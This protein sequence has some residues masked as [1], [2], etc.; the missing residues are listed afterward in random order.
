MSHYKYD[1]QLNNFEIGCKPAWEDDKTRALAQE[2]FNIWCKEILPV[3]S[4]HNQVK[5][6]AYLSKRTEGLSPAEVYELGFSETIGNNLPLAK[7]IIRA[8]FGSEANAIAER[9]RALVRHIQSTASDYFSCN[10]ID[11][12][13][14]IPNVVVYRHA[15]DEMGESQLLR[16]SLFD[17]LRSQDS[18]RVKNYSNEIQMMGANIIK[19]YEQF[20]PPHNLIS[21]DSPAERYYERI[22][23]RLIPELIIDAYDRELV[24]DEKSL[25]IPTDDGDL[26]SDK[27]R[28]T[29]CSSADLLK[30]LSTGGDTASGWVSISA[31]PSFNGAYARGYLRFESGDV[32][33]WVRLHD[34]FKDIKLTSQPYEIIFKN[35]NAIAIPGAMALERLQFTKNAH[36]PTSDFGEICRYLDKHFGDKRIAQGYRHTDL[37]S[38]NILVALAS[39]RMKVIDLSSMDPDLLCVS[40]ARLEVSIWNEVTKSFK[41]ELR[42]VERI[43]DNL[44]TDSIPDEKELPWI[45]WALNHL[46]LSLRRGM[47]GVMGGDIPKLEVVLAYVT[48]VLLNQR[49]FLEQSTQVSDAFN[50]VSRYWVRQLQ[51]LI[52]EV[53]I[54]DRDDSVSEISNEGPASLNIEDGIPT[55]YNLW[56]EALYSRTHSSLEPRSDG[57]LQAIL[58]HRRKFMELPLTAFQKKVYDSSPELR[59]FQSDLHVIIA[60]PTSSGKSTIAEMFLAGPP[61]LN[62]KRVCALY[63]APTRALTQAKYREL[64]EMFAA[65]EQMSSGIVLSTGEDEDD[66]WRINHGMFSIACMVY[67]KANILFSHNRSLLELIGCI[68]VDEMHMLTDLDRGPILE[69]VLTKAIWERNRVDSQT[70]RTPTE[71]SLRIIAISTEDRPDQAIEQFLSIQDPVTGKIREPLLFMDSNRPVRV[72]HALIIPDHERKGYTKFPIVEF[73]STENRRLSE[74]AVEELSRKLLSQETTATSRIYSTRLGPLGEV[75]DRLESLLLDLLTENPYGYRVLVF[76]PSRSNAEQ[77]ANRLKNRLTKRTAGSLL[78]QLGDKFRHDALVQRLKPLLDNSEDERKAGVIKKCAQVGILIH[79][80]DIDKKIRREI[81]N[82]CSTI[83]PNTP[84]QVIVATETLSYGVNLAIHDVILL[85]TEFYCQTRGRELTMEGLSTCAFH[86]MAGRAGRLGKTGGDAH[87]YIMVPQHIDPLGIIK[88]YYTKVYPAQSR[89]YVNDDRAVQLKAEN[90]LFL[91]ILKPKKELNNGDADDRCWMYSR[92]GALNFSY[93]FVRSVLDA[94]RHLN[95]PTR[96]VSSSSKTAISCER[97][98]ELVSYT[99]FAWQ[100][101]RVR[102]DAGELE[103]FN[104]AIRRILDDCTKDTLSLVEL[105]EGKTNLYM[106]TPRG[107]A[108]I[109]TGTEIHTVEPL[110]SI[111]AEVQKAWVS[112]QPEGKF[113]TDLYIL[114]LIAQNEVFR[115]YIYYAPECKGR[116]FDRK[117]PEQIATANRQSVFASFVK[118]IGEIEALNPEEANTL[119]VSLRSILD[120]WEPIRAINAAYPKGATDSL[121]RFFNGIVAWINLEERSSVDALIEGPE[122][123]EQFRSRMQGFRQFTDLL[124]IKTLFLAKMLV[125]DKKGEGVFGTDDER[126][127][128]MLASRLRLGCTAEAIPLFWPFSSDVLRQQAAKFL[129]NGITPSKLLS[130]ADPHNLVKKSVEISPNKL[131]ELR[132]DLEKFAKKEFNELQAVMTIGTAMDPDIKRQASHQLWKK[133]HTYFLQ[134]IA[135]FRSS[136]QTQMNF[137]SLLRECFDFGRLHADPNESTEPILRSSVD[138][139]K[140]RIRIDQPLPEVGMVWVVEQ[141][142]KSSQPEDFDNVHQIRRGERKYERNEVVKILGVQFRQGWYCSLNNDAWQPFANI[143]R[144]QQRFPHLVIV[145]LP[146]VPSREELPTDLH[147]ILE[148]RASLLG[149]STTFVTPAAFA[150]IVTSIVRNWVSSQLCIK[151]LCDPIRSYQ[152]FN[153]VAV[154]DVQE[155]LDKTPDRPVQATIREKLIRHFEVGV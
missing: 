118:A 75:E 40:Q 4:V 93:P 6:K 143:L 101:L 16:D 150:A 114:C 78:E 140:Y 90:S 15:D 144:E 99:L 148:Q 88:T 19:A 85:G 57:L 51:Q 26:F 110:L 23:P 47:S 139:Y 49:Y 79:H 14:S 94:L 10:L 32:R 149:F 34:K 97:L 86:N 74:E 76:V 113:P 154:K 77:T 20:A 145:P 103:R 72:Q 92:L 119:A 69:M 95:I 36:L 121:L 17:L 132:V 147:D 112:M 96:T 100:S 50:M 126:N 5:V 12:I 136:D 21:G 48:Q 8:H 3:D 33:I 9:E 27:Q 117:W 83:T 82:I 142:I 38:K 84:S 53:S 58:Q 116:D 80:S 37:H 56:K 71:E 124:N 91:P 127:M 2:I 55:L 7:F 18:Q 13:E 105:A 106:I 44:D 29:E 70:Q 73:I 41:L 153:L 59:P 63:I 43:L 42:D 131:D 62:F 120:E 28:V 146:W 60:S 129:R 25:K 65:H 39:N 81:E 109:D 151:M 35:V 130:I 22:R 87:V 133:M 31:W 46:L 128:H 24:F 66:D 107:E 111:V 122:L 67:E 138:E 61:M 115:Q 134:S 68:V 155:A 1:L 11:P 125:T 98:L 64:V 89:L 104:C 52:A 102:N 141:L 135:Q 123:P 152:P 137:D 54:V 30:L 45:A 108:I